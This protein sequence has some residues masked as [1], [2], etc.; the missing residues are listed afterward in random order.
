[1]RLAQADAGPLQK[2]VY[3]SLLSS[4]PSPFRPQ[5]LLTGERPQLEEALNS[6]RDRSPGRW[7]LYCCP[8]RPPPSGPAFSGARRGHF[9]PLSLL[10]LLQKPVQRAQA[11]SHSRDT[12]HRPPPCPYPSSWGQKG[13]P[14]FHFP[15][16]HPQTE[17]QSA[18]KGISFECRGEARNVSGFRAFWS[19]DSQP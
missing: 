5:W 13:L 15:V 11:A 10:W 14:I 3:P 6:T 7:G 9:D 18:L 12:Q 16:E 4:A 19:R 1:M 17:I 2:Q 8:L